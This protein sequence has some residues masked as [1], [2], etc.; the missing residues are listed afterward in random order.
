MTDTTTMLMSPVIFISFWANGV[1]RRH[2]SEPIALPIPRIVKK[3]KV[4]K[5]HDMVVAQF[6]KILFKVDEILF[7]ESKYL[8]TIAEDAPIS[9]CKYTTT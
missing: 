4:L 1:T 9:S 6:Y 2:E 5:A 7:M 3:T 8:P